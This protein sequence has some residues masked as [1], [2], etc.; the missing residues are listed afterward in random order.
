LKSHFCAVLLVKYPEKGK[1]KSRLLQHLDGNSVVE[2]Y[3]NFVL[4]ILSTLEISEIPY[5]IGYSPKRVFT[6]FKKWLGFSYTYLPQRGRGMSQILQNIF[7]D[8]YAIGYQN[9]LVIASDCPDIP[10]KILQ[11]A[12]LA[13]ERYSVVIGPS[14]DGGYYLIGFTKQGFSPQTFEAVTWSTNKVFNETMCKLK[15]Q[16]QSIHIL[17]E[18]SDVD[19]FADL[20]RLFKR[21]QHSH[22]AFSKTMRMLQVQSQF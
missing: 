17:P 16:S 2:L 4:D 18:W 14:T 13:L 21:N 15:D 5:I 1:V 12:R 9:V 19:T 20:K 3:K 10:K 7:T 6:K 11:E 22:F 8:T